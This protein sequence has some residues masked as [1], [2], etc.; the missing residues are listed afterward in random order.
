MKTHELLR[1]GPRLLVASG[2]PSGLR[3]VL[4]DRHACAA[5]E[6]FDWAQAHEIGILVTTATDGADEK[7]ISSLPRLRA[8]CSLGVGVDAIDL[9]AAER[10]GVLVSN[11]PDVLN[12]CVADLAV[13]LMIDVAR[14]IS[15]GDRHVRRGNWVTHGPGPLGRRVSGKRLGLV[16]FGR[17]AR[18]IAQRVSGF[19]MEVRY[20]TPRPK[21]DVDLRY[22]ESVVALARWADFLVIACAGGSSTRHLVGSEVLEALGQK[23]FL[24]NVARGSIVD[25]AALVRALTSSSV[26]GAALDVVAFEPHVPA[27][28]MT[29][30]NV[31]TLPHIGSATIETRQA[32]GDLLLRNVEQFLLTG[33]LVTPCSAQ[34]VRLPNCVTSPD[35]HFHPAP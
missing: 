19:N 7:L 18:T 17:I 16:G 8:V 3:R 9:G 12:D 33:E 6:S 25:E 1:P 15:R 35:K 5:T 34:P 13:G 2:V 24:I 4:A 22:E 27:A 14:G 28:L 21:T 29:F 31:V 20:H 10:N 32:M 23:G 26:G 11:T 30:D